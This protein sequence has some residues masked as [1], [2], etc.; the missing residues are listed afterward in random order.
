MTVPETAVSYSLSGNIV[1]VIDNTDDVRTASPRVVTVG[2]SRD[3]L[4]AILD[5]VEAGETVVSAGQNKLFRGATVTID[6]SVN[7]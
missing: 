7:F 5:G 2:D 4:I 1:Y 3:G 6:K